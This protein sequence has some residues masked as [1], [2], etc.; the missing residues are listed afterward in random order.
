MNFEKLIGKRTLICGEVGAGKTRLLTNFLKFLV[1][2][3]L[4]DEIT[5]IDLAPDYGDIG[6]SVESYYP[7]AR[8]FRYMRPDR[9]YPPRLLSRSRDEIIRYAEMNLIESRKLFKDYLRTPTRILLINDLT[10]YFHAGDPEDVLRLLDLCD[11][12]AATA[13]EGEALEDDMGS[14]I[15]MREKRSLSRIKERMDFIVSL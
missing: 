2:V 11:T 3:G 10:I 6:R 9:I 1:S 13:Y 7:E 12:F 14:G 8:M 15:T 4:K 5:V